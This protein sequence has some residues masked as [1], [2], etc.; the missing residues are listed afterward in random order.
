MY[1][2]GYY[3]VIFSKSSVYKYDFFFLRLGFPQS[4]VYIYNIHKAYIIDI[5][6]INKKKNFVFNQASP[7]FI[8]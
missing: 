3:K 4:V 5:E 8:G 7:H 6:G 2:I 1:L